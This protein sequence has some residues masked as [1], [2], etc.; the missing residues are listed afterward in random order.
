[1]GKRLGTLRW[2]R[3]P[4]KRGIGGGVSLFG[5][6]RHEILAYRCLTCSHLDLYV[7]DEL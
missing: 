5:Q 4:V 6:Q 7:G 3:T 1:M 2:I